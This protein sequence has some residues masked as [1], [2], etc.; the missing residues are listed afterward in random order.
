MNRK[1]VL[2]FPCGSEIGLEV[3]RSVAFSNYFTLWGASSIR[4]HGEFMYENYIGNIPFYNESNYIEKIIQIVKDYSIDII[5][6]TMDSIIYKL[7]NNQDYIPTKILAPA[8]RAVEVC[9]DKKKTYDFFGGLINTPRLFDNVNEINEYPVFV[10]PNI[11][12]GARNSAI[13]ESREELLAVLQK[14]KDYLVCEFLPGKEY[15][16]DCFTDYKG[17][18][19][20]CMPRER[21]RVQNG[22]SVRS[23][24]EWNPN[25]EFARVAN[26]INSCLPMRGAWFFQMKEGKNGSFFLLEIACR[27][28][29]GSC[30]YLPAGLN[31]PLLSLFD[32]FKQDIHIDIQKINIIRD[33]ALSSLYDI[34]IDYDTVYMD[35]DDCLCFK[36]KLNLNIVKFLYQCVNQNKKLIL[37]T[38]HK[39]DLYQELRKIRLLEIWDQII[40]IDEQDDKCSY[41]KNTKSV[42]IDDSFSERKKVKDTF[43]IPVF[44]PDAVESLICQKY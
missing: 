6:P 38:K 3:N 18:L 36:D 25:P 2:V 27:I 32:A 5:Y 9:N 10:K 17:N 12:Y 40:C 4:D 41:I 1:N 28:G 16:V 13:I 7:R 8:L 11:G 39:G 26:I 31:L 30:T 22:I 15:T 43:A 42:F 23:E 21:I 14:R 20:F 44:A 35:F 33:A 29:G 24:T 34:G 19:R 37:L